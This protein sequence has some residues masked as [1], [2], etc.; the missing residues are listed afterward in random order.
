MAYPLFIS[1]R[2]LKSFKEVKQKSCLCLVSDR[3]RMGDS[4]NKV[5][6]AGRFPFQP[7]TRYSTFSRA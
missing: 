1:N 6:S 2:S 3:L 4:T 5:V 7:V